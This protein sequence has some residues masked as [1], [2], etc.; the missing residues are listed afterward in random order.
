MGPSTRTCLLT[1]GD[2]EQDFPNLTSSGYVQT[3]VPDDGYNCI[4]WAAGDP[5]RWWGVLPDDYWPD[6]VPRLW[7]VAACVRAFATLRYTPGAT[8]QVEAGIEKV[9][10]YGLQN[11]E[12][13]HAAKQLS[14][15]QWSSKLGTDLDISHT[16][17][18]LGGG[19][20]GEVAI[21]LARTTA[22]RP[23]MLERLAHW[24]STAVRGMFFTRSH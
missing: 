24:V 18:G 21:L 1:S 14:G 5:T 13:T 15:G 8:D 11:G 6:G 9:A 3:S 16:L 2:L 7:T 23:K 19:I 10:I 22:M 20:Y 4:A 17:A 12:L